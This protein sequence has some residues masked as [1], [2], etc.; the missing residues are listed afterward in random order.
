MADMI[1]LHQ[2]TAITEREKI[3]KIDYHLSKLKQIK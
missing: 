3:M 1:L 2:V